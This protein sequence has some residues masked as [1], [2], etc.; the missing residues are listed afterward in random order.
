MGEPTPPAADVKPASDKGVVSGPSSSPGI[1]AATAEGG[2]ACVETAVVAWSGFDS[3][4]DED[5]GN[6]PAPAALG[7]TGVLASSAAD[8]ADAADASGRGLADAGGAWGAGPEAEGAGGEGGDA[9]EE[10]EAV[11]LRAV[12]RFS[13]VATEADE[14]SFAKGQRLRLVWRDSWDHAAQVPTPPTTALTPRP[15]IHRRPPCRE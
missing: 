9:E 12:A 15:L 1:P 10:G 14:V 13:Y 2:G 8:A 6:D 4:T 5:E 3:G 7:S 11:D